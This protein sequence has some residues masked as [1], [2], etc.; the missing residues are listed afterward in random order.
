MAQGRTTSGPFKK[1]AIISGTGVVY[2][3]RGRMIAIRIIRI[4]IEN[5][6]AWI[7][8]VFSFLSPAKVPTN[9]CILTHAE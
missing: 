4:K 8:R 7:L 9:L 1:V 3:A 2:D 6:H 5:N